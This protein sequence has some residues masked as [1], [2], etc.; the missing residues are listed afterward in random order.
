MDIYIA[1]AAGFLVLIAT[2]ALFLSGCNS[3]D[4]DEGEYDN[5]NMVSNLSKACVQ[6]FSE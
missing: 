4:E 3:D 5:Y 6:L 2:V 1:W